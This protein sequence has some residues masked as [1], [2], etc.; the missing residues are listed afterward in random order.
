MAQI[1]LMNFRQLNTTETDVQH[2]PKAL[3]QESQMMK[4]IR[5]QTLVKKLRQKLKSFCRYMHLLA[6]EK[7]PQASPCLYVGRIE[8]CRL[9][10]AYSI[11]PQTCFLT[12]GSGGVKQ[13]STLGSQ[14]RSSKI[15][16]WTI[17]KPGSI[18][19]VALKGA[20][21]RLENDVQDP[22]VSLA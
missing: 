4:P 11:R 5:Y 9:A 2:H 12:I 15:G 19:V 16:T 22:G 1:F 8:A 7:E 3:R 10:T 21:H 6:A 18:Q 13:I 20:P 14:P 17:P